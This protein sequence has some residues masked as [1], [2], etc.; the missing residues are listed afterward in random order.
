VRAVLQAAFCALVVFVV[1]V[2][3]GS[4]VLRV[5]DYQLDH[6]YVQDAQK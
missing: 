6:S 3:F 1:V 2:W 4:V 5:W